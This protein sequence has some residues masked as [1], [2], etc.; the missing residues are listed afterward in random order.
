VIDDRLRNLNPWMIAEEDRVEE[1]RAA[2]SEP[3]AIPLRDALAGHLR[4]LLNALSGSPWSKDALVQF[5]T[6]QP[7]A[8]P[9][10]A[11][12]GLC[13]PEGIIEELQASLRE[14]RYDEVPRA[15]WLIGAALFDAVVVRQQPE[16][17][18]VLGHLLAPASTRVFAFADR[19][20]N[21][22]AA[23]LA[24]VTAALERL[25]RD[26]AEQPE[27]FFRRAQDALQPA[28]AA[29]EEE[30][31]FGA[32][33]DTRIWMG[34]DMLPE[35]LGILMPLA[36][37]RP[38][39]LL[40]L[41]ERIRLVPL[42]QG[43]MGWRA[44]TLDLDKVLDMLVQAPAVVDPQTGKWN[45][46]VVAPI[47]LE[48]AF[49]QINQLGAN[50]RDD[51]QPLASAEELAE[52]TKKIV[53]RLLERTDGVQ[54]LER[55]VR[56]N[57]WLAE[58]KV[59]NQSF[60][61]VFNALLSALARTPLQ[62]DGAS[63]AVAAAAAGRLPTQLSHKEGVQR[64]RKLLLAAMLGQERVETGMRE[65]DAT[66]RTALLSLMRQARDAFELGYTESLPSWRHYAFADT[67]VAYDD[68]PA[69]WRADF[70]SFS[71]ERR[72]SAH[73]T[74]TDDR[75]LEAPSL[76]FAG[77]GL[78]IV[79]VCSVAAEGSPMRPHALAAWWQVFDT[80]RTYFIHWGL[81]N[82]TWRKVASAL[83]ARYPAAAAAQNRVPVAE[84]ANRWLNLLGRDEALF[85]TAIANMHAN[86]L[87]VDVVFTTDAARNELQQRLSD[88][89]AWAEGPGSRSF[90][91]GVPKYLKQNI[92]GRHHG[93]AR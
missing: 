10:P 81:T 67:Y 24:A 36:A 63:Q 87:S 88:Y 73:Y 42:I 79:E 50:R 93:A 9:E 22:N 33:W 2:A 40:P 89:V 45:R 60:V 29:W 27:R 76:F 44:I 1:G 53:S 90:S 55:W 77:I 28:I 8:A 41:L 7:L 84:D 71:I 61:A 35:R 47:L 23:Q 32:I 12:N 74:Y 38:K 18:C 15:H 72:L 52:L 69:H 25:V 59:E 78:S 3:W 54:L 68:P 31:D 14:P 56:H 58:S 4:S 17:G 39:E 46:N 62:L 92:I 19:L 20:A 30:S 75:S 85:T 48:T 21:A 51:G 43:A 64:L 86:G 37:A 49:E 13:W 66:L 65:R 57:V 11:G 34:F 91:D 26:E 82:G 83:F 5:C 80:T 6:S 70:D 16:D